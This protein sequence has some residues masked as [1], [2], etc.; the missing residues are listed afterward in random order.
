MQTQTATTQS[1][2]TTTGGASKVYDLITDRIIGLL[3]QG[4]V[5][6]RKPWR[7]IDGGAPRNLVSGKSYRGINVF[8]LGCAPYSSPAWLTFRQALARG[9]S[10]RKG[11]KGYPVVFWKWL[12]KRDRDEAG[13]DGHKRIPLLRYYTVFN[14][15]QCEG[16]EAPAAT[17]IPES[18]FTTLER[19]EQVIAGMPAAPPIT[20]NDGRAFYQPSTDRVS[21][22]RPSLFESAPE[23]YNTV[24]HELV[25]ATGH[26]KRLGRPGITDATLFGDH[27]YSK[28]EL[29]AEMGAAFLAGHCETG[30]ETEANSAAYI[31]SWL[32]KLRDDKRLV[33]TAAAQAQK[34]TDHILGRRFDDESEAS[35][36]A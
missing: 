29:V 16:I 34:A 12:D 7:T 9:G 22:P 15:E 31:G 3:E 13:E 2:N 8:L 4:T 1:P 21:V 10:V 18:P 28:E 26:E 25:H 23:Y 36:A 33:V 30:Q 20:H 6:W 5:P 24:F 11:E 27:A 35:E 17:A 32:K 19:C 14:L